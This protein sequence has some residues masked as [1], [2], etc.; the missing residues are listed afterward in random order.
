[1]ERESSACP[2][3]E[4]LAAFAEGK[5][6]GTELEM[7]AE[8]LRECRDCRRTVAEAVRL[9]PLSQDLRVPRRLQ[10]LPVWL[11]A[12]AALTGV[13]YLS[14]W[15][16]RS[17]RANAPMR[18]LVAATPTD[19]RYLEPRVSGGFVWAPLRPATR[20]AEAPP[21]SQMKLIGAAGR[22]IEQTAGDS[23]PRARHA[24]AVARLL[25][26]S[27]G[28][29]AAELSGL[30]KTASDAAVWSDLAAA[31]FAEAVQREDEKPKLAQALAA[32]DAALRM[33]PALPEAL[34]N[35][36]LILEH[37]GL[38]DAARAAWQRYLAVDPN[39]PWAREAERHLRGLAGAADFRRELDRI[40]AAVGRDPA[41]DGSS[42]V[43]RFPQ[44]CRVWGESEILN[45]WAAAELAGD[46]RAAVHLR[47]ARGFGQ[48]LSRRTGEGLLHAAVAAIDNASPEQRRALADAHILFRRAQNAVRPDGP[49]VAERLYRAAAAKFDDG[50]SPM[51]LAARY[52]AANMAYEQGRIDDAR[53]ELEELL[54]RCPAAFKANAAGIQWE[55]G[56]TYANKGRWGRALEAFNK[57]VAG[58]QALG[59]FN[60]AMIVRQIVAEVYDRIGE[61]R[62]AWTHRLAALQELG[63]TANM[64]LQVAMYAVAR[65]AALSRD[66]PVG[67]SF[68]NLQMQMERQP[69]DEL[70]RVHTLLLRASI[71]GR[72]GD[73]R[74]AMEDLGRAAATIPTI[75]DVAR[76][77]RAESERLAVQGFLTPS[78]A[79][80]VAALSRAI[81]Y[82]R[83]KG[84]RMFL[85]ELFLHRGRAY[86]SAGQRDLA[87][88]D[89]EAG[90][91]ELEEQ[92]ASIASSEQRWGIFGTVDELFDEAVVLALDSGDA[93]RAFAYSERAR[94]R[95]LLESMDVAV[96]AARVAVPNVVILE[97]VQLADRMIIFIVEG[98]RVRAVKQPVPRSVVTRDIESLAESTSRR[99]G[100]AFRRAAKV[101]YDRLLA[102]VASEVE[103][104]KTLVI[105]PDGTLSLVPFA[106]LIDPA[107]RYVVERHTVVVAPSVAVFSRGAERQERFGRASRLLMVAGPSSREG[108]L[109]RLTAQQREIAAIAAEYGSNVA[110]APAPLD[111]DFLR[112]RAASA[113]VLHFV[114]HAVVPDEGGGGA[115]VTTR[116]DPLDVRE[117]AA[118]PFAGTRLVVLAACGTARG[119]GRAGVATIS[120]AR[121]FL[122]AGVPNVVGTLWPI[123]DA[124]SAEFF[125]R[126]HQHLLRGLSPAEALRAVQ[127]EWIHR[128]DGS[129]AVW[130]AV[131]I[132]GT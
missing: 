9:E 11:A 77:E 21:P 86:V 5:L 18:T 69:G 45:R 58:F 89:F 81:D 130:A 55:L 96:P 90:I 4:V 19:G 49:P 127:L 33:N 119:H 128:P 22:V 114:G 28:Q 50:G 68:L 65:G 113:D 88:G 92:R 79:E 38:R 99:D 70:M 42:L 46:A 97:Y 53:A 26:G 122:A 74:A 8:H 20:G 105:V 60:N 30:A 43:G 54:G 84:R 31:R 66:W 104:T 121:A 124:P 94:A 44:E 73:E 91:R 52:F 23:S 29:A 108:D 98:D 67:L 78:P 126:F 35:R 56:L 102:P 83:S 2:E 64:R 27:A 10:R 6:E 62:Q 107:G 76:R 95:E 110:Y 39:T 32:A 117:I 59:E 93:A 72:M 80:A 100:E 15:S 14:F 116:D 115:L 12:A 125:P 123:D 118:L 111:D 13:G 109:G 40:Y 82:Q 16:V 25:T 75:A 106:A 34:F 3:P 7:T 51:A 57:S 17:H 41:N 61:P 63:R 112:Q 103:F 47:L 48:E 71:L 131:Q 24:A 129:P 132:I 36:A 101:L 85:P 87:A 1:V 120:V 37:L